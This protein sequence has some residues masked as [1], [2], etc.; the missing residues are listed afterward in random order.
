MKSKLL[1]KVFCG[2]FLF[3]VVIY[4]VKSLLEYGQPNFDEELVSDLTREGRLY[5]EIGSYQGYEF[6]YSRSDTYKDSLIFVL[7]INGLE[8]SVKYEGLAVKKNNEWDFKK[9]IKQNK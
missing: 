5:S 1:I 8:G 9:I 6:T 7:K 3:Y 4:V 2:V